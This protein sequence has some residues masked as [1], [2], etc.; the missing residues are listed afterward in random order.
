Y[1]VTIK[2]EENGLASTYL[3]TRITPGS[4]VEVSAPRGSFTLRSGSEPVVLLSAGVGVTPVLAMLHALA[5][6]KSSHPAW[7]LYGARSREEHPLGAGSRALL[8]QVQ[9]A[10]RHSRYRR[11]GPADKRGVDFDAAGHLAVPAFD[12]IGVPH[13]GQFYLC[14]PAAFL[15]ELPAGLAAW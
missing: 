11:P 15:R 6:G 8:Q 14:G 12:Q 2:Q 7:W 4:N 9:H 13:E 10:H 1:R 5:A 3:R